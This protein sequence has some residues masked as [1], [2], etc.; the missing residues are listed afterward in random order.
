M[1]TIVQNSTTISKYV[2]DDSVVLD[3]QPKQIITPDFI[4]GDMGSD[5]STVY[6]NVTNVPED[7]QGCKYLFDGTTWTLNPN[8][9]EPT[10]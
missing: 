2:F 9:T 3:V 5:N 1:K 4:I 7:W 10:A 6:E 8:W